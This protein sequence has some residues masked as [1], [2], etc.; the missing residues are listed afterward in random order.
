MT[1]V[2]IPCLTIIAVPPSHPAPNLPPYSPAI[3]TPLVLLAITP[4][5]LV[6]LPLIISNNLSFYATYPIFVLLHDSTFLSYHL[7]YLS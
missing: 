7:I 5:A 3:G 4:L 1:G 6:T 2:C